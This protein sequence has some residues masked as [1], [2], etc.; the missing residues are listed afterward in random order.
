M[1]YALFLLQCSST[2]LLAAAGGISGGSSGGGGIN[3][4]GG[5][6][7]TSSDTIIAR[8]KYINVL[9]YG[10]VADAIIGT[11]TVTGVTN[12]LQLAINAGSISNLP[13]R[14]PSGNYVVS[15][16][17]LS[18]N[19]VV[20]GDGF[21]THLIAKGAGNSTP[22][23]AQ[24]ATGTII[25]DLWID[26]G[27]IPNV[28]ATNSSYATN[29][30]SPIPGAAFARAIY[31]N[32]DGPGSVRG[33]RITG[34]NVGIE[35]T[36]TDSILTRPQQ[37]IYD[38]VFV[39]NCTYGIVTA[40]PNNAEYVT[41]GSSVQIVNCWGGWSNATAANIKW[42]GGVIRD[43]P[44]FTYWQKGTTN[45]SY[46]YR[47]HSFIN[48][49]WTHGGEVILENANNVTFEDGAIS[50]GG[51]VMGQTVSGAIRLNATTNAWF[52]NMWIGEVSGATGNM[53]ILTNGG[54]NN[55]FNSVRVSIGGG[56]NIIGATT[57][58]SRGW[59]VWSDEF[60]FYLRP[61]TTWTN[62]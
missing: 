40:G 2:I 24:T 25:Q 38:N 30:A 59:N 12:S 57:T 53:L 48:P 34:F 1:K 37:A 31:H 42:K 13:V 58:N 46:G 16:T 39:T 33:V 55:R 3:N 36:G 28:G 49:Y 41:F 9:D 32:A 45:V 7:G 6:G 18:N 15:Q 43:C 14:I 11:N 20:F 52:N 62:Q 22:F 35:V 5:S 8:E 19:S 21:T 29:G 26:R 54:L 51:Q 23:N 47:G 4:G 50:C 56:T 27:I 44:G 60:Q 17:F 61:A 10:V